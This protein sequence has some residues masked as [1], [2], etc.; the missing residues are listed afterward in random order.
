MR[1]VGYLG[2]ILVLLL[3]QVLSRASAISFIVRPVK[4]DWSSRFFEIERVFPLVFRR[5]RVALVV[6]STF[7][8]PVAL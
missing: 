8:D 2:P 1:D 6:A 7:E 4:A 3:R 5:P